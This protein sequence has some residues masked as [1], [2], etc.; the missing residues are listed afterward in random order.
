MYISFRLF[1]YKQIDYFPQKRYHSIKLYMIELRYVFRSDQPAKAAI[2]SHLLERYGISY[3]RIVEEARGT[4]TRL[5]IYLCSPKEAK[6]VNRGISSLKLRGITSTVVLLKDAD[7][8]TKWKKD[9]RPFKITKDIWIVPLWF[10]KPRAAKPEECVYIDTTLA[11]GSGLHPTTQMTAQLIA[12]EKGSFSSLLDLGTGSGILSLIAAKYGAKHIRAIDAHKESIATAKKNFAV[13]G[14]KPDYL[15]RIDLKSFKTGA[16]F[17]L[18]TAN[19]STLT[20]LEF[21]RKIISLIK[22]GK[23]LAISG[24]ALDDLRHFQKHFNTGRLK[25]IRILKNRGWS[26]ILYKKLG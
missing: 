12:R 25:C 26:A 21:K 3:D 9:F 13:N 7:W 17:D 16:R 4:K 20:L 24:V 1:F 15:K 11:F 8:K 19:L 10:R 2:L 6:R 5:S 14:I 23:Y 22:P 18:V